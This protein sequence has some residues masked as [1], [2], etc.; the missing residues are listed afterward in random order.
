[1]KNKL[2]AKKRTIRKQNHY[3]KRQLHA[4]AVK[5][6]VDNMARE[7]MFHGSRGLEYVRTGI[8]VAKEKH[9]K[10]IDY[11]DTTRQFLNARHNQAMAKH[12]QRKADWE[13]MLRQK[14]TNMLQDEGFQP[15]ETYGEFRKRKKRAVKAARK[16]FKQ[17]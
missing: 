2:S 9:A 13:A 5:D 11:F 10:Y 14:E 1:L 15:N 4:G 17:S 7:A 16:A 8:N 6:S 12:M 3:L